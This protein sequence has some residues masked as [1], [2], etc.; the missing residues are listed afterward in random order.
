MTFAELLR[1]S[2]YYCALYNP[3]IYSYVLQLRNYTKQ[4]CNYIKSL[5]IIV[6]TLR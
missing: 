3:Y 2:T 4:Y 5:L 1:I 6:E